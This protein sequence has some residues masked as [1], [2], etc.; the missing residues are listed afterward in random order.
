MIEPKS[1]QTHV[2]NGETSVL[3]CLHRVEMLKNFRSPFWQHRITDPGCWVPWV[4]LH[5]CHSPC[6]PAQRC[7]HT[8][9]QIWIGA[10][11]NVIFLTCIGSVSTELATSAL[12]IDSSDITLHH[13]ASFICHL[14][15]MH[16]ILGSA[17][18]SRLRAPLQ[19]HSWKH[20]LNH[21]TYTW[22]LHPSCKIWID[23]VE[24]NEKVKLHE[25]YRTYRASIYL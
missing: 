13:C 5:P 11:D 7:R 14:M 1:K 18:Q 24:K 19:I 2:Q 9:A 15:P 22:L 21:W 23:M 4:I 25:L 6:S 12:K 17:T 3:Q 20:G 10:N 8:K 16:L